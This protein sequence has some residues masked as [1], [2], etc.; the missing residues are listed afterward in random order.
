MDNNKQKPI[1]DVAK[2]GTTPESNFS[3]PVVIN[4]QSVQDD[5]I[6]QDNFDDTD[7]QQ[8]PDPVTKP[9]VIERTTVERSSNG[10][11]SNNRRPLISI[12]RDKSQ[13]TASNKI[14][15]EKSAMPP[16][17]ANDVVVKQRKSKRFSYSAPNFDHFAYIRCLACSRC[18]LDQAT[19]W[20]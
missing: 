9:Q 12:N 15:A 1:D 5:V 2:P 14:P 4:N 7:N 8:L 6:N 13:S 11:S 18:W 17:E 3:R 16:H 10:S 20:T 19:F